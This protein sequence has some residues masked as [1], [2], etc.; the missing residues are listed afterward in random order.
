[1]NI[2][3]VSHDFGLLNVDPKFTAYF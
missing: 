1:V 3:L 2:A